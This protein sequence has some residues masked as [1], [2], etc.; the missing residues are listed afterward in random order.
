MK[1]LAPLTAWLLLGACTSSGSPPPERP[2]PV[3]PPQELALVELQHAT[4]PALA[5]TLQQLLAHGP[6]RVQADRRTNS[7]LLL[8]RPERLGELRELIAGLDRD[9]AER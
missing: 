2:A 9:V 6:D 1:H 7:I 5:Q 8:A 3:R 4:A